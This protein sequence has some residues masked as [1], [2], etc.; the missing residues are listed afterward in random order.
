MPE[1]K[2]VDSQSNHRIACYMERG[3]DRFC[4]VSR[5]HDAPSFYVVAEVINVQG[6][7][8][9]GHQYYMQPCGSQVGGRGDA[10][11]RGSSFLVQQSSL[12]T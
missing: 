11:R 1:M 8:Y 7:G 5:G 9:E 12:Q 6:A 2:Q 4:S 10:S 3:I